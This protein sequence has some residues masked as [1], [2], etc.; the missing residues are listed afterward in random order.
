MK[1]IGTRGSEDKKTFSEVILN[2]AAPNG[3]LYCP[4]AL[5]SIDEEFITSHKDY[6]SLAKAVIKKF[7]VDISD[8]SLH[9]AIDL[10]DKFDTNEVVPVTKIENN[11]FIAELWHGPT[12]AFKDMAL[13]PFGQVL[14][15]LAKAKNENYLILA[16]T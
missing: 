8:E 3:G 9:K 4:E 10:Y 6:K 14:S 11:L 5:P 12:R 15:D 2:P 16:A 1:F 7:N 13:Q